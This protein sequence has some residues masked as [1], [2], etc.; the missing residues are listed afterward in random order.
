MYTHKVN[1]T[2]SI[3]LSFSTVKFFFRIQCRIRKKL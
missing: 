1:P 3:F 2:L